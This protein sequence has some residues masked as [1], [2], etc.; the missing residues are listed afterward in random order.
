MPDTDTRGP[1]QTEREERFLRNH[2]WA[3]IRIYLFATADVY[4]RQR[5]RR[6]QHLANVFWNRWRK[7][8][9]L[10]AQERRKWTKTTENVEVGDVVLVMDDERPRSQW[11]LARV[12]NTYPGSDGLVRKVRV[13]MNGSE[14]R[15]PVHR[16]VTLLRAA[17]GGSATCTAE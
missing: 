5:W 2:H 14:H 7:E 9:V 3:N 10:A 1:R 13:L 11:P 17:P 16:L 15:R 4:A 6:V 12:V 8:V